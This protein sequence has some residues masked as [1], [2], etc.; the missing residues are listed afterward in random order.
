[1]CCF[2]YPDAICAQRTS[3]PTDIEGRVGGP[4][5]SGGKILNGILIH[6]DFFSSLTCIQCSQAPRAANRTDH[7]AFGFA[8]RLSWVPKRRV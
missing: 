7:V 3:F 2:P 5:E 4:L 6:V 1:M 8:I